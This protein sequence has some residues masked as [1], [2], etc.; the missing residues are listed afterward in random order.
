M[1]K[2]QLDKGLYTVR[3]QQFY[4]FQLMFWLGLMAITFFSLTLWYGTAELP[5][6]EHTVLQAVLGVLVSYPLRNVYTWLW[7]RPLLQRLGISL[8]VVALGA[9]IWTILRMVTFI[10]IVQEEKNLWSDF[11]GWYF[12]GFFI[13][14]C[15]SALYY[16]LSYYN[17]VQFEQERSRQAEQETQQEHLKRL[18][19]ETVAREAQLKMLRYQLNPHFL[20]NT[21]NT[22][23]A[24]IRLKDNDTAQNMLQKLSHFLRYALDNEPAYRISLAEELNALM[25]YL[26]I[27][28]IRFG[29]RLSMDV[30]VSD[31]AKKALIP[32]LLLQPLV[33]NAIKYAI[34]TRET[35]GTIGIKADIEDDLLCLDV[36]D[37]G[38]GLSGGSE[39]ALKGRGV[40]LHNTLERLQNLYG[41]DHSVDIGTSERNG[42][43]ISMRF[44][45]EVEPG[46]REQP[47]AEL[48]K[49]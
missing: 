42:V 14:L 24:L 34:S 49:G 27:E 16:G 13:F 44:P 40:G 26:N 31:A 5:H 48:V 33:E 6:I 11:G 12:G 1:P 17:Q 15:W 41:R 4:L 25:L 37:D 7:E 36:W 39:Q 18:E 38:P 22:I 23:N 32:S 8:L 19:A 46:Q 20:F 21:L 30:Q 28:L 47:L 2:P 45:Y 29:D 3:T 35:G 9:G 43:Q 10:W